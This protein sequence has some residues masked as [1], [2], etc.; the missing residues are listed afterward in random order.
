[1]VYWW[2][3]SFLLGNWLS[4]WSHSTP[5]FFPFISL[6]NHSLCSHSE[7]LTRFMGKWCSTIGRYRKNCQGDEQPA[8]LIE[9]MW[10]W[11]WNRAWMYTD[12]WMFY[13]LPASFR[14]PEVA[15]IKWMDSKQLKI[16]THFWNIW[17]KTQPTSKG[18]RQQA[19]CSDVKYIT[20]AFLGFILS[21]RSP[22]FLLAC[23][24]HLPVIAKKKTDVFS[25]SA[26]LYIIYF[27]P[28]FILLFSRWGFPLWSVFK[29]G[30]CQWDINRITWIGST[31]CDQT[32][33][34]KTQ[35]C[36][37]NVCMAG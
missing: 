21:P 29:Q 6:K 10:Y 19:T 4:P 33:L 3:F 11:A 1:M 18:L 14:L 9:S 32:F 8:A 36:M 24:Q 31:F 22:S 20:P 28:R 7:G 5:L 30:C 35:I 15:A 17:E 25:F 16:S 2:L 34:I 23:L 12:E 13:S 26:F 37:S 27:L